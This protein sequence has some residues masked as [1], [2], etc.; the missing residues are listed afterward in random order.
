MQCSIMQGERYLNVTGVDLCLSICLG[1]P[2][3][4]STNAGFIAVDVHSIDRSITLVNFQNRSNILLLVAFRNRNS[5]CILRTVN[6]VKTIK[7]V[8]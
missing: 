1:G 7:N 3:P 2:N 6:G 8:L 5:L 4:T